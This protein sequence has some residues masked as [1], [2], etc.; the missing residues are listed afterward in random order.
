MSETYLNDKEVSA[1][2]PVNE[3]SLQ[4]W[5]NT[6]DGPPYI[7]VGARRV[8]YRESDIIAW[9][10]RKTFQSHEAE[11]ASQIESL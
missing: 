1:R 8:L 11:L 9:M 3:R 4:R 7:R 5:R 2:Y 10:E 6:G